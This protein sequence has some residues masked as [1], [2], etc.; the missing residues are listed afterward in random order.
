MVVCISDRSQSSQRSVTIVT[1]AFKAAEE[2]YMYTM[3]IYLT[4]LVLSSPTF[5]NELSVDS[6]VKRA[7]ENWSRVIEYDGKVLTPTL[8]MD[9]MNHQFD[10]SA[11]WSDPQGHWFGDSFSEEVHLR[12]SEMLETD[13]MQE[14]LRSFGVGATG[15]TYGLYDNDSCGYNSPHEPE[16]G[17]V[18]AQGPGRSS[19]K[20]VVGWLKLKAALRWSKIFNFS[21]LCS[22]STLLILFSARLEEKWDR[23]AVNLGKW[24]QRRAEGVFQGMFFKI[25]ASSTNLLLLLLMVVARDKLVTK[26]VSR[27]LQMV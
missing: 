20:A 3:P 7:Y 6:L 22:P 21:S 11:D 27:P 23:E 19:G 9:Q 15:P 13:D 4:P 5:T 10:G 25:T 1:Y 12:S 26:R 24:R 17:P 8:T 18:Y 16:V 2:S 14:L